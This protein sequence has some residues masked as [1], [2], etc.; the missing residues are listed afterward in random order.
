MAELPYDYFV[1]FDDIYDGET[2][3][4]QE[5]DAMIATMPADVDAEALKA[6]I[7]NTCAILARI[8]KIE[9]GIHHIA[10]ILIYKTY[11]IKVELNNTGWEPPNMSLSYPAAAAAVTANAGMP[12]YRDG[13]II[14]YG[15]CSHCVL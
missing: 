6:Q 3:D 11:R 10:Q 9:P 7:I 5:L 1:E 13:F 14:Y 15:P 2:D 4:A 8:L 12:V